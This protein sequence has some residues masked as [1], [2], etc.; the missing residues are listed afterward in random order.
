MTTNEDIQ[1]ELMFRIN[2]DIEHFGGTLPEK[3]AIAWRG[4][5]AAMLEWSLIS[6]A[7]L[8]VA[9]PHPLSRRR[10]CHC[11]LDRPRLSPLK[12]S[13]NSPCSRSEG[14]ARR[15]TGPKPCSWFDLDLQ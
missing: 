3:T 14:S 9:C 6:V 1:A 4:Y 11:D 10:S 13:T 12:E 2:A 7:L 5:L 8:C 15:L